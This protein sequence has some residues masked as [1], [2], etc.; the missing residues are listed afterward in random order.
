MPTALLTRTNP[1]TANQVVAPSHLVVPNHPVV[2]SHSVVPNDV[3][4]RSA[5]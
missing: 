4:V 5:R 2:P 1:A 3:R